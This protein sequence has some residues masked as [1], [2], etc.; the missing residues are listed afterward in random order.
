MKNYLSICLLWAMVMSASCNEAASDTTAAASSFPEKFDRGDFSEKMQQLFADADTADSQRFDPY[1]QTSFLYRRNQFR[2]LWLQEN[3]KAPL[4][5]QLIQDLENIQW[6]GIAPERYHTKALK[7]RLQYFLDTAKLRLTDIITLDTALTTSYL[8]AAKDLLLGVVPVVSVD[9]DW[10]HAND[11]SW[12]ISHVAAMLGEAAYV[13]LDSFRSIIPLYSRLGKALQH[14]EHLSRDSN[15]LFLCQQVSSS[16]GTPADS[17]LAV[18]ILKEAPWLRPISDTIKGDKAIIQAYQQY[19]GLRRTGKKDS[20]TLA[21]IQRHPDSTA[22]VIKANMERLRW[23]P[24]QLGNIY[25]MVL[26]PAMELVMS[27]DGQEIMRMHTV[28]G[29]TY[30]KTPSL[31]APMTNIVFNPPW[32][33][34][35]TILKKD[36]LPG[37]LKDGE[38]HL[39]KKGLKVYDRDGNPADPKAVTADNYKRFVFRQPPGPRN[40][41]GLIKFNMPNKWDI[42][43][44]D[45]PNR[46]DFGK[47]NR[48]KSS[49]CVRIQHPRQMAEYI[50]SDIEG[51]HYTQ[52]K[53]DSVIRT[54]KTKWEGVK[55][56]LPV[57]IV[58]LTAIE[59]ADKQTRF[60]RD[61]YHKD[62]AL[63]N[64]VSAYNTDSAWPSFATGKD[65]EP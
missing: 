25:V 35:P 42:Y 36:V 45:T 32:G 13:P 6:D 29:T 12:N 49:G 23:L 39:Q 59:T 52:E 2:P 1:A 3:G 15:F 30:R 22:A 56:K 63:I 46:E 14:Y 9:T 64:A 53:I 57:H 38:A 58:Y 10:Y 5:L 11:S 17:L 65:S 61:L 43:L 44:H 48:M 60:T 8:H 18:T 31:S 21:H 50:L 26:I 41:L 33:V 51:R 20:L 34:P 40:A 28:I 27:R 7:L 62:A 47:Y 55:S 4:A 37:L 19:Y 54:G 16:S 24:R